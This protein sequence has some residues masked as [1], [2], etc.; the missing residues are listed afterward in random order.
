MYHYFFC[1]MTSQ[2]EGLYYLV[3]HRKKEGGRSSDIV[4]FCVTS[5]LNDPLVADGLTYPKYCWWFH[6]NCK[7]LF[8]SLIYLRNQIIMQQ[9]FRINTK[10]ILN[11]TN[12]SFNMLK[13][14]LFKH[15]SFALLILKFLLLKVA[16]R[17]CYIVIIIGI[18]QES[19]KAP[20]K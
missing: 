5:F 12:K 10:T 17:H 6:M 4:K 19:A 3:G 16:L 20:K 7:N 18:K 15:L 2:G 13:T 14:P 9:G 8:K 11:Q 1:T